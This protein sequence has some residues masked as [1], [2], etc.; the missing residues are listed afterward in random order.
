MWNVQLSLAFIVTTITEK[1]VINFLARQ[2]NKKQRHHFANKGPSSQGYGFSS[3]H[4]W[5]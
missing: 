5:M 3:D 4:V 1:D 2:H